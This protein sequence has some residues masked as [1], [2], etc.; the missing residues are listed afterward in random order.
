MELNHFFYMEFVCSVR[1]DACWQPLPQLLE[2][3]GRGDGCDA[4]LAKQG[5]NRLFK[6]LQK[7]VEC[8]ILWLLHNSEALAAPQIHRSRAQRRA[9][10]LPLWR[11]RATP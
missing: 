8:Q 3:G 7:C 2:E 1:L 6:D 4:A 10:G 5:A 9:M 11:W